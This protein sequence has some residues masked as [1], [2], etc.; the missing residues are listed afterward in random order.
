METICFICPV[1]QWALNVVQKPHPSPGM[2]HFLSSEEDGMTGWLDAHESIRA[3][4]DVSH[5]YGMILQTSKK[6][7][8]YEFV[9]QENEQWLPPKVFKS[10]LEM[11]PD[12]VSSIK[13]G[14]FFQA[15]I[16]LRATALSYMTTGDA[17]CLPLIPSV[18]GGCY[19]RNY[20][21]YNRV[22]WS[23]FHPYAI[24]FR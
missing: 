6:L 14:R 15:F 7:K 21:R 4:C 16:K 17:P 22:L 2:P 18:A 24:E 19:F 9:L 1:H 5:S 13:T 3:S 10:Y 23:K 20:W 8:Y 11:Y 12:E